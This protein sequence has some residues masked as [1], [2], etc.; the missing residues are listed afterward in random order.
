MADAGAKPRPLDGIRVIDAATFIA[1]PFCATLL[2]EF[3]AEVIK[4]ELP[5]TGDPARHFGSAT[6]CGDSLVWLN[7]ARNKK[8]ITLDLRT[9]DGAAL[10]KRLAAQADVVCEN[11]RAGTLERWGLGYE[12][13]RAHNAGLVMVRITGYGQTGPYAARPGFG[14]IGNAF[15]G[16]SFLA[17]HP[18]REP[19]T[20]GSATLAD[21]VSGLFGA[22]GALLAL[23]A[24][25]ATGTGQVV[26][27]GL[28]ES[29]FRLLD[30]LVP[31]YAMFGKVRQR[32][33]AGTV[34]A[35]P[36]SHYPTRDGTWVAIACTSDKMFARLAALMGRPE[37]AG[38]GR[39]ATVA[40]REAARE[41]V[42]RMV[43]DWTRAHGRA[44]LLAACERAEVPCGPVY[45]IDE[46]FAD[47][48]Y[49]ARGNLRTIEDSRAGPVT[50]AEVVPRLSETPGA[51]DWLGPALGAHLA[52]VCGRLLGLDE[53]E[54]AALKRRGVL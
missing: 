23:R 8:S 6:P 46:I 28:Y 9:A 19:V 25:E 39:L 13:L 35:V 37:L 16:L 42:D 50:V 3:G 45:A 27:I 36:H 34:N 21:Y 11:F 51:I 7:E 33:G 43:A 32:I 17:G 20:P 49:R 15:G 44:E 18:D 47:P 30:E 2:G 1:A 22:F 4:V 53:A 48:Q 54:V 29:I 26:D 12:D 41:E 14:R 5:G 38:D 52:E 10:F 31:A 40:R 24:R